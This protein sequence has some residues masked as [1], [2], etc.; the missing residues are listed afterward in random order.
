M[1]EIEDKEVV[2][3][4]ASEGQRMN[5]D[6]VQ[7]I[8]QEQIHGLLFGE[9]LSWQQIIYDLIN[10]Q[11]FDPWD[12]DICL[13][14]QKFLEKVRL[15][16]EANF[17]VSSKV[18]FA[19]ALLLRIKSEILLETGVQNL[20]DILYGKKEDKKYVQER[21]ELDEEI[22]E[23]LVRTPLPRF[24]KVSLEELM[25][26][27]D[28]AIKT[29]NR[30]IQRVVLTKQQEFETSLTLP[31]TRINIQDSINQ[32]HG[33]L[34]TIFET[35]DERLAFT[36]LAGKNKEERI[37]AFVPLL[38]LDNQQK[39]WLEQE[40]HC[41]EIWI[42]LKHMYES[43][44][45]V[46]LAKLKAEVEEEIGKLDVH[47]D[48]PSLD[49]PGFENNEEGEFDTDDEK[50]DLINHASTRKKGYI[51]DEEEGSKVKKE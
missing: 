18:L 22:P 34:N 37:A 30:R 39:V 21:L 38:H 1:E 7:K 29:E 23:L 41:D 12:L 46:L 15:L 49:E 35:R 8:D 2:P 50:V 45:A 36:E 26:A 11:Q 24:K 5:S 20:D 17:F 19:A 48:E 33:K 43:K 27:L 51:D 13:L 9:T 4:H 6:G 14:A 32:I 44:N 28:T 3:F 10:T 16:E 31:K 42:L 47:G 25:R 40:G